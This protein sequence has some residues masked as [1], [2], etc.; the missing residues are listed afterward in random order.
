MCSTVPRLTERGVDLPIIV[1]TMLFGVLRPFPNGK[2]GSATTVIEGLPSSAKSNPPLQR[3]SRL[4]SVDI[5]S[6]HLE[7]S[8]ET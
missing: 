5:W 1:E 8:V 7:T 6:N 3:V 2:R 4:S